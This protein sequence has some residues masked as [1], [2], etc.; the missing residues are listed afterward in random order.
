MEEVLDDLRS[1]ERIPGELGLQL[2][3][4][5]TEII[6]S[7]TATMNTMLQEVPGLCATKREWATLLGSPIGGIEGLCDTLMA[8]TRSF[9]VVGNR[10]QHLHA[11]NAL[12]LLR[13]AFA[14]PKLLYTLRTSP[15]F[16][17]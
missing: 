5:K 12:C 13:Y 14:L 2:N 3:L 7:D 8:K 16:C 9:G 17:L 15:C 1:V 6:C 10:L 4:E 11:H